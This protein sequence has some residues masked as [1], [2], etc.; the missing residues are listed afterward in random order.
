[1][2]AVYCNDSDCIES[3]NASKRIRTPDPE[4]SETNRVTEVRLLS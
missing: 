2:Y 3:T 4:R 1:M